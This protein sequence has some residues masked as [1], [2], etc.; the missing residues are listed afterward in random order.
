M[1]VSRLKSWRRKVIRSAGGDKIAKGLLSFPLARW[2]M[3]CLVSQGFWSEIDKGF[4]GQEDV[5][6]SEVDFQIP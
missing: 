2:G 4:T 3:G 5:Q 1:A 6:T